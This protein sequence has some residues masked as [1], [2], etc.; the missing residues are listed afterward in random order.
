MAVDAFPFKDP[1]NAPTNFVAYKS[2]FGPATISLKYPTPA[3]EA[4]VKPCAKVAVEAPKEE[5]II[6]L[7]DV[8]TFVWVTFVSVLAGFPV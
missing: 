4:L 7:Y 1:S 3:V 5:T 6:G 8:V 2:P